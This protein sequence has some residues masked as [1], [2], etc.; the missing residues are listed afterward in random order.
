MGAVLTKLAGLENQGSNAVH[1]GATKVT[2]V[3]REG[4]VR[5]MWS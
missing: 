1:S 4:Q 3:M 5:Y 2:E